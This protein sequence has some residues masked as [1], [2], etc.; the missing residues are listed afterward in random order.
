MKGVICCCKFP[1]V[2]IAVKA[3]LEALGLKVH[4]ETMKK[5][6]SVAPPNLPRS[7]SKFID[8]SVRRYFK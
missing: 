1:V 4:L 3:L 7:E 2:N 8:S 6:F 5:K